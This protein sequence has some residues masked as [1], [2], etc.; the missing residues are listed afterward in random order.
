MIDPLSFIAGIT[1]VSGLFIATTIV[2]YA[3][4]SWACKHS[5]KRPEPGKAEIY[6]CGEDLPPS[7]AYVWSS[8]LY[9]GFW[10]DTFK[11]AY[12]SLR[13]AHS[14]VLGDWLWWALLFM[15]ILTILLLLAMR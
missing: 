15:A 7:K 9:Q 2:F 14:G 1:V 4:V 6:A 11:N 5:I 10:R 12:A 8:Q 3:I 13:G